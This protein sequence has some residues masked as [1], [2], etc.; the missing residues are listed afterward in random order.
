MVKVINH[1]YTVRIEGRWRRF[2]TLAGPTF[3]ISDTD[4]KNILEYA[5]IAVTDGNFRILNIEGHSIAVVF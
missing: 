3:S 4:V 5:E 1:P 2:A